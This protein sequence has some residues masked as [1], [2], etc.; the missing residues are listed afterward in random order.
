MINEQDL[1]TSEDKIRE[2]LNN[3]LDAAMV[4]DFKMCKH[5][6]HKIHAVAKKDKKLLN[7]ESVN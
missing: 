3:I 4:G 2:Y 7:R 5:W 1:L 6:E